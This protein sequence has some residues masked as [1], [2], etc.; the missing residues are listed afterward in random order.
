MSKA[1]SYFAEVV[2]I[3]TR[4]ALRQHFTEAATAFDDDPRANEYRRLAGTKRDLPPLAYDKA[5]QLS[6][7]MWKRNPIGKRM[8][9]IFVDFC[10]GE[11]FAVKVKIKRRNEGKADEDTQRM[12]AQKLW[13]DFVADP[14]NDLNDNLPTFAQDLFINGELVLP[15]HVNTTPGPDGSVSGN[16]MVRLGYVDPSNVK[17]V[18]TEPYNML[19]V[20]QLMMRPKDGAVLVPLKVINVDLDA[21]SETFNKLVGE[22]FYFRINKVT[23]QLRGHGILIDLLDWLDAFDQFLFD[24]LEGVRLRNAFF[25]D[26]EMKGL[27]DS[28]IKEKAKEVTTPRSGSLRIHNENAK[29]SVISPNLGTM[30]LEKGM[31]M[32]LTFIVGSKGFPLMWFGSGVDANRATAGEMAKPTLRML[33]RMQNEI[34]KMVKQM[35]R[36]VCDAS[37]TLKLAPN[38]YID[39]EVSMVDLNQ[40]D[41]GSLATALSSLFSAMAIGVE[42]GWISDETAKK[43]AD[44]WMKKFGVEVDPN[45][46]IEGN[47]EEKNQRDGE[48]AYDNAPPASGAIELDDDKANASRSQKN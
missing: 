22:T 34:R 3:V 45:E 41:V 33:Q 12:D 20:R 8:I 32:F 15:V 48:D 38:E 21:T 42:R 23:N 7:E 19:I 27:N 6:F 39:C 10:M 14:I 9:E 13:E 2:N 37:L 17:E 18:V 40:A 26:L 29:Y 35:V 5:M 1:L 25:Y 30:D 43:L 31:L 16:G 11:E 4:G 24:G 47:R 36:F 44:G 28:Q 46:T